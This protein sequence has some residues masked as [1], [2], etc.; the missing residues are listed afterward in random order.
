[1]LE[2]CIRNLLG[3]KEPRE[4][5]IWVREIV[6]P[7]Q[8]EIQDK[9][10]QTENEIE[11]L[12]EERDELST[13]DEQL[14]RWKW[15]LWETGRDYLESV[16]RE[17]LTLIG[18]Q[19]EPQP[20]ED[21]D[22]KVESEFGTALLEVEGSVAAIKRDK[23]GQLV[24]NI[25]NFLNEKGIS[26]KGIFIGN[27]FRNERLENRP[28]QETQ[29]K[30]FAKEFI[31]DAEKHNIVVLP[32]TDLYTIVCGILDGSIS[33]DRRKELRQA[34]FEGKGLIRLEP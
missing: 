10:R 26:A 23:L 17:A 28:P 25:G 8:K 33:E 32:S 22:G 16:V 27:P 1:M 34:I 2:S 20:V 5:P 11:R 14:E 9:I 30:L 29:K 15:L 4:K 7:Q 18:C 19:I 3:E 12:K 6:L 24:V 21:S 31:D 13:S